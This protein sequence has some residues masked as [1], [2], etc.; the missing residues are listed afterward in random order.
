MPPKEKGVFTMRTRY[1]RLH[2]CLNEVEANLIKKRVKE[3]KLKSESDLI[4]KLV[5]DHQP[6][7]KPDNEFYELMKP[8]KGISV[9]LNNMSRRFHYYGQLDTTAYEM[10]L[11]HL[12]RLVTD[13]YSFVNKEK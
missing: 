13:V 12:N 2:I 5:V 10:L 1:R 9:T 7:P 6:E 8:F 11:I 3:L 4:R